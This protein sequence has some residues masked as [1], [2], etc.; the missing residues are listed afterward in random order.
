MGEVLPESPK[1]KT[2]PV[3][4]TFYGNESA[5]RLLTD[6]DVVVAGLDVG[7][8]HLGRARR[9]GEVDSERVG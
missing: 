4:D 3:S 1:T 7:N 9:D 5:G 2:L 8:V 6:N